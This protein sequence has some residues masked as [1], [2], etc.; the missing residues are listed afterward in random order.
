MQEKVAEGERGVQKKEGERK[1]CELTSVTGAGAL[2]LFCAL[3]ARSLEA[4]RSFH[5]S[6]EP[7]PLLRLSDTLL[8]DF[9]SC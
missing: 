4:A 6:K 8:A 5:G 9:F 2:S 7:P 3:L 1:I